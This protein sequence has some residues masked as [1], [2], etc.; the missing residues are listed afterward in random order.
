MAV[1][2]RERRELL[3]A[4]VGTIG[5][6]PTDTLLGYLP[7][8]GWADVATKHDLDHFGTELRLEMSAMKSD[9]RAEIAGLRADLTTEIAGLHGETAGLR[10]DLTTETAGLRT[11]LTTGLAG[12]RTD[13]TTGLAGL[14][15]DLTTG[16]AGLRTEL[17]V[18]LNTQLRWMVSLI[19]L[20]ILTVIGT[21]ILT[22]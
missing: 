4:L 21:R 15:T 17:H 13:L 12:L 18:A 11:D 7:P 6:E 14:R 1:S 20:V 5:P 3:E 16:L 19:V 8:V 9:L 2:D 22:R 10:T